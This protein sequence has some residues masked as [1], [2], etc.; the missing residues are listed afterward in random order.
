MLGR[1]DAFRQARDRHAHIGGQCL[2]AGPQAARRPIGVV[3]CLP[4]ARAVL[5]LGRPFERTAGEIARDLAETLGLLGDTRGG[6]MELDE[7]HRHFRQRQL[8]VEI[9]GF[10][11]QLVEQ[12]D[13]RHRDAGLD[14]DDRRVAGRLDRGERAHAGRDRLGNAGELERELGD[15]AKRAFRADDQ[16]GQIVARRRLLGAAR[17]GH[18]FAVRQHDLERQHVVFHGAVAHRIGAGATRRRHTAE[19]SVGAGIERKEQALIA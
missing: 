11:L 2:R 6:A 17:G 13:A 16:P 10:D 9:G 12:F 19:R 3:P 18:Q 8:G 4:Q 15:D 7:Q 1:G 5:G 14:G